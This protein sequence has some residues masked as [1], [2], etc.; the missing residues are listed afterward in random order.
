MV[1]S[2][3]LWNYPIKYIS[4]QEH[5]F[6]KV[7]NYCNKTKWVHIGVSDRIGFTFSLLPPKNI[8]HIGLLLR[9]SSRDFCRVSGCMG[10]YKP[11]KRHYPLHIYL[12]P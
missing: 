7:E 1:K 2:L 5:I 9:G 4:A 8:L 11:K 10:C 12:H 6:C 3:C